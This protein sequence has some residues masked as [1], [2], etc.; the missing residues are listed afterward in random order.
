MAAKTY[1]QLVIFK[2]SGAGEASY[3]STIRFYY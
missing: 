1:T 3:N 2:R